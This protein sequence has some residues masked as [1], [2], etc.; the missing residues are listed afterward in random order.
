MPAVGLQESRHRPV[1]MCGRCVAGKVV[2]VVRIDLHLVENAG[3]RQ[4]LHQLSAVLE[5]HV[6]YKHR[7]FVLSIDLL[8][9]PNSSMHLVK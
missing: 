8:S 9:L 2:V 6:V 5:V 3:R 7:P 4:R 1:D